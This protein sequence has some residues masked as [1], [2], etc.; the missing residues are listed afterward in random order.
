MFLNFN[1]ESNIILRCFYKFSM[2][3]YLI[4]VSELGVN[5]LFDCIY[6]NDKFLKL[7]KWK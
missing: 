5:V 4:E 6:M 3:V 7:D 1:C 2:Y